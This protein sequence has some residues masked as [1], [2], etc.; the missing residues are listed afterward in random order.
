MA[1]ISSGQPPDQIVIAIVQ[2]I[3]LAMSSVTICRMKFPSCVRCRH[4]QTLRRVSC[5]RSILR[6]RKI[7]PSL[8]SQ[9]NG[10]PPT[11]AITNP[12]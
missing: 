6:P 9:M 10:L 2:Q 3:A 4:R 8:L 11:C 1:G 12:V 7:E 5:K